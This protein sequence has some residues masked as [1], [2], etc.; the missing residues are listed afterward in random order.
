MVYSS[1][2]LFYQAGIWFIAVS[3]FLTSWYMVYNSQFFFNQ[4]GIWFKAV[5]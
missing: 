5:N 3:Y 2:L 4:V 1:Q